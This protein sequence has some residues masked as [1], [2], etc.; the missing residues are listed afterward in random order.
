MKR[1]LVLIAFES[2]VVFVLVP[3]LALYKARQDSRQFC[4]FV[5]EP[6]DA[7]GYEFV[8]DEFGEVEFTSE[9]VTQPQAEAQDPDAELKR[10]FAYVAERGDRED[11][12]KMAQNA[13]N[14][15]ASNKSASLGDES[16][17]E[18]RGYAE[19]FY[20]GTKERTNDFTKDERRE[21]YAARYEQAKT[22]SDM[23]QFVVDEN[24]DDERYAEDTRKAK[25]VL[26]FLKLHTSK[27]DA[28]GDGDVAELS[29][30]VGEMYDAAAGRRGLFRKML[31]C[32]FSWV[33]EFLEVE[34]PARWHC[35]HTNK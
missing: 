6:K 27:F 3:L 20:T 1:K 26:S 15:L 22:L 28:M 33:D 30:A 2:I 17:A 7:K 23:A 5:D 24:G 10:K 32:L 14:W 25:N 16:A 18:L 9:I 21:R 11:E 4:I 34:S 8:N 19:Q 13:V 29:G 12:R 35:R 31:D